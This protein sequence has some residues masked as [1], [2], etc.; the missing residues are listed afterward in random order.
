MKYFLIAG[1]AS[2]DLH[3]SNLIKSIHSLDS[4]AQIAC[5]GGD[6][7]RGAGAHLL[8]HYRETAFMGFLE[9][10][11]NVRTIFRFLEKCKKDIESFQPDVLVLID[12]P[13]FNLR[14]A[15]WAHEKNYKIVYYISPQVWAWKAGRV[16]KIHRYTNKMIVILPFEKDFY[17]Q[18]NYPVE[19]VGHPLLDAMQN[20]IP[21]KNFRINNQI[22]DGRVVALLPGSREQ[23]IKTML[24]LMKNV[25]EKFQ[26]F[27]FIIGGLSSVNESIYK[28]YSEPNMK[29]VIDKTYDL[30]NIAEAAIVTSGTAT[31]ET[32]LF[33]VPQ[34]VCYKGS[35]ISF[36]IGKRLVNVKYIS[37]VNLIMNHEVVR[38]FI[39]HD[40]NENSVE[41]ELKKL[42]A[43]GEYIHQM[44]IMY[45]TL[46]IKLGGPGASSR[47]AAIIIRE[48]KTE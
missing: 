1:E 9:V 14:M 39:Q 40:A 45:S 26:G 20:F 11:K 15:E 13:G 10:L 47:A 30:L 24:P 38:E 21:D 5:W 6:K 44:K 18:Y 29:L 17:K 33:N 42:L 34:M 37:L 3:G 46:R 23:E 27:Q 19:F 43:D 28:K 16:R 32:A 35:A 8:Q 25:A 48:A 4:A 12:Y 7:M 31:L 41:H 22:S 36:W 2:G